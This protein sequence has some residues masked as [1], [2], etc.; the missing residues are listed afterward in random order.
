MVAIAVATAKR[1]QAQRK[2]GA[3]QATK[4]RLDKRAAANL[5]SLGQLRLLQSSS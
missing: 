3:Q 1:H 5:Q 2:K 4:Q